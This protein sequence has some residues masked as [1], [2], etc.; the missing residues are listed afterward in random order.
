MS[1]RLN[2]G[3]AKK[4]LCV[5]CICKSQFNSDEVEN[6]KG[7]KSGTGACPIYPYRIGKRMSVKVF[8]KFCLNC[9][10]GNRESVSDCTTT[11]CP[12]YE[13]RMGKN[14]ACAGKGGKNNLEGLRKYRERAIGCINN[15][16][17]AISIPK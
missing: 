6:C 12:A 4:K 7:D 11:D 1:E 5:Q 14:P 8:R 16:H 3:E 17:N 15:F 13:F 10:G 9:M 2:P